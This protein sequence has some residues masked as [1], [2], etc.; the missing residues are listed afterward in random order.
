MPIVHVHVYVAFLW[1]QVTAKTLTGSAAVAEKTVGN[2]TSMARKC[3]LFFRKHSVEFH[4][5]G[6]L[7]CVVGGLVG[8]YTSIVDAAMRV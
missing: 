5:S 7:F 3:W 8:D 4:I 2:S 1:E 6:I